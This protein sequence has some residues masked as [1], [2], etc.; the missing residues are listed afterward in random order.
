M[1]S[2]FIMVAALISI[3]PYLIPPVIHYPSAIKLYCSQTCS[4]LRCVVPSLWRRWSQ[5]SLSNKPRCL[6]CSR[7]CFSTEQMKPYRSL[8]RRWSGKALRRCPCCEDSSVPHTA[9]R[10]CRRPLQSPAFSGCLCGNETQERHGEG[11]RSCIRNV[12]RMREARKLL[13]RCAHMPTSEHGPASAA[14]AAL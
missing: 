11:K 6:G 5:T 3:F 12:K 7:A 13:C 2:S 14:T 1:S 8:H 10:L 9:E 4:A